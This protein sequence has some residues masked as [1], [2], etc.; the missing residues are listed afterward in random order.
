[1]GFGEQRGK[2]EKGRK[3]VYKLDLE[4]EQRPIQYQTE[5]TGGNRAL[6]V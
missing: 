1:M 6:G 4:S 3:E 2:K 5:W